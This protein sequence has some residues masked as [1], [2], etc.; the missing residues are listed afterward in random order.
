MLK[1]KKRLTNKKQEPTQTRLPPKTNTKTTQKNNVKTNTPTL[2]TP[3]HTHPHLTTQARQHQQTMVTHATHP[4][5]P[6]HKR[7]NVSHKITQYANRQDTNNTH[8]QEK[9]KRTS[10]PPHNKSKHKTHANMPKTTDTP[11]PPPPPRT[12][13]CQRPL[14]RQ[15]AED[16]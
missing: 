14:T 7:V 4:P 6:R 15:H 1:K 12:P 2:N 16:H 11:S 13:T 8:K 3:T 10:P 9:P 5:P